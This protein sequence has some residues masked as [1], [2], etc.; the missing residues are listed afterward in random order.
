MSTPKLPSFIKLPRHK[1]FEYKPLY[2][3]E[4]K[5]EMKQ[6]VERAKLE[7]GL[8]NEGVGQHTVEAFKEKLKGRWNRKSYGKGVANSNYRVLLILAVII[9]L[10]W[11]FFK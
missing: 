11:Y 6:R 9:A 8:E 1:N 3:N 7:L 5:E 2:Y 4:A 10:L